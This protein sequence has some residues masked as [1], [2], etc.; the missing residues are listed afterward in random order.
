MQARRG[1]FLNH[2]AQLRGFVHLLPAAGL[3]GFAEIAHGAI[4]GK[5]SGCHIAPLR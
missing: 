4:T 3:G 1:M 5:L 2:E